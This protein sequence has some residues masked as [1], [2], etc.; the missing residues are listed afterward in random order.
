MV[1][2]KPTDVD[3]IE[4]GIACTVFNIRE[5]LMRYYKGTSDDMFTGNVQM[6]GLVDLP[7]DRRPRNYERQRSNLQEQH[8]MTI[9]RTTIAT[10]Q[11]CPNIISFYEKALTRSPEMLSVYNGVRQF[12]AKYLRGVTIEVLD[13][14]FADTKGDKGLMTA[15]KVRYASVNN[16]SFGEWDISAYEAMLTR[17]R[18]YSVFPNPT[19]G[20]T[21]SEYFRTV[22]TQTVDI[23]FIAH[24]EA[25][26]DDDL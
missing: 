23:P 9:G 21:V 14:G 15:N 22:G 7:Q 13:K 18:P 8:K 11:K 6:F 12:L 24:D 16:A 19:V 10:M 4:Y 2:D 17:Q 25:N 3:S 26:M 1:E 20:T 5:H